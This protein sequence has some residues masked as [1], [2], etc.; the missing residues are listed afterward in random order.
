VNAKVFIGGAGA[1]VGGDRE[2]CAAPVM[3]TLVERNPFCQ[4]P[5]LWVLLGSGLGKRD[6]YV[7]AGEVD[8]G[9]FGL[10][11]RNGGVWVRVP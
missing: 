3:K 7:V 8:G 10:T 2:C 5:G 11:E 6:G 9:G 1:K 4:A